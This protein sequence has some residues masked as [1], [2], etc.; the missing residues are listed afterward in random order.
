MANAY[1]MAMKYLPNEM[2]KD[3]TV[4]SFV[5][6]VTLEGLFQTTPASTRA[7]ISTIGNNDTESLVSTM[8]NSLSPSA[9]PPRNE[10]AIGSDNTLSQTYEVRFSRKY[11]SKFAHFLRA[12][13]CKHTANH[14]MVKPAPRW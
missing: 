6:D 13:S 14:K 7:P 10:V 4:A 9:P 2:K 11:Y 5:K 1:G 8:N 12:F 3:M